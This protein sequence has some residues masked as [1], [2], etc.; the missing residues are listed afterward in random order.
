MT[1]LTDRQIDMLYEMSEIHFK[2]FQK[3]S[4]ENAKYEDILEMNHSKMISIIDSC[5]DCSEEMIDFIF[6]SIIRDYQEMLDS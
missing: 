3:Y 5:Q 1:Q 2:W 4:V 6:E